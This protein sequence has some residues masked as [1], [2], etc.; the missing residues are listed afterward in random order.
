[1][2]KEKNCPKTEKCPI[3]IGGVLKR[4]QSEKIYRSLFCTAGYENYSKCVRYIIAQKTK[5][6]VPISILP[7]STKPIDKIIESLIEVS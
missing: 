4:E 7:N 6:P 2:P 3:F 1:M 5:K